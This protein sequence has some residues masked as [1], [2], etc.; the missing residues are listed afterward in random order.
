[1]VAEPYLLLV[2][3]D[4]QNLLLLEELLELEGYQ[5]CSVTNGAEA[6]AEAQR[7]RPQLIVLDVMMPDLNGFQVCEQLRAM[8]S[9]QTVPI[10]FLTA[11]DDDNS[12]L[13]GLEAMGDD[14]LTKPI[15]LKIVAAKVASAL[16]LSQLR[17]RAQKQQLAAQATRIQ[18][19]T[20]QLTQRQMDAAWRINEALS[21]KFRLFVPEQFLARIAP[22]G[23]ESIQLG[24][25][26]ESE[27]TIMFC[28]IRDF[29]AI[30]STQEAR[31]TFTWLNA[32]FT[33][34]SHAITQHGGYIDKYLGDAVMAVFDHPDTHVVDGINGAIAALKATEQFSQERHTFGLTDPIRVGIGVHTGMA[35]I[36]TVGSDQRMDSTVIG[37][38]VNTASRI[39][40]LTKVYP[41]S[42]LVSGELAQQIPSDKNIPL[43]WVDRVTLR[44]KSTPTDLYTL[45]C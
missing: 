11:L 24:N 30:A 3:D 18:S 29:T 32:L 15:D 10:I 35:V 27:V 45:P 39:E 25:V 1:M 12:R 22:E 36:G 33:E 42:I 37:D 5:T 17:D 26:T 2:D 7:Q 13:K 43:Q 9:L 38:V 21:E 16:R 19:Q 8:E 31:E 14:Y 40:E 34:I 6:I 44:G 23:V 4:L 20:R 28:D 41:H